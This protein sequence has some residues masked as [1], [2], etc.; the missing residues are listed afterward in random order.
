MAFIAACTVAMV[1]ISQKFGNNILDV[2]YAWR[3]LL[4][5][6][7]I[8]RKRK[9]IGKKTERQTD[10]GGNSGCCNVITRKHKKVGMPRKRKIRCCLVLLS[11]PGSLRFLIAGCGS[12]Y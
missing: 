10:N 4:F 3:N 7:R 9:Y 1:V 6:Y 12:S 5:L 8:V 11:M 2:R